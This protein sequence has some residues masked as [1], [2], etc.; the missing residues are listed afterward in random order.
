MIF[1]ETNFS[2]PFLSSGIKELSTDGD[3]SCENVAKKTTIK[4]IRAKI[5][6]ILTISR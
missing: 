6:S 4:L 5:A 2:K 1:A 3:D